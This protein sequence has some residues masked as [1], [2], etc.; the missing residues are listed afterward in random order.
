MRSTMASGEKTW[1]ETPRSPSLLNSVRRDAQK[2]A[3]SFKYCR[4]RLLKVKTSC[5]QLGWCYRP[6]PSE[7]WCCSA[8]LVHLL[9]KGAWIDL[10]GCS[11]VVRGRVLQLYCRIWL[12]FMASKQRL[13]SLQYAEARTIPPTCLSLSNSQEPELQLAFCW[14]LWHRGCY[15]ILAHYPGIHS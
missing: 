5:L 7:S 11:L 4:A 14:Y 1:P 13:F 8:E 12:H 15:N 6:W 2:R 3:L 9:N 10:C